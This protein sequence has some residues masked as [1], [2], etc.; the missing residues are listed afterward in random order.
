[1]S[2]GL[3]TES[4]NTAAFAVPP[5]APRMRRKRMTTHRD[6]QCEPQVGRS[7]A[8]AVR[9]ADDADAGPIQGVASAAW[10]DTYEGLLRPDTIETYIERAYSPERLR[11]RITADRFYVAVGELG[12]VAFADAVVL[13]ERIELAAIYALPEIRGQGAGT[14][15][16][17]T[18]LR[19]LPALPMTADV[20][21]GN[22]KGEGFYEHR[23]FV[24]RETMKAELFGEPVV[25]RRWWRVLEVDPAR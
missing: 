16:L 18:L 22:R 9:R 7:D 3:A 10:R 5:N 24:A 25:E 4:G 6:A 20:L 19:V 8:W 23:G 14:A 11:A 2:S 12:I 15:L 1:M 17:R 21:A 13:P